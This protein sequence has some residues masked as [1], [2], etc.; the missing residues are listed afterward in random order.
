MSGSAADVGVD[1][2]AAVRGHRLLVRVGDA[3]PV[4]PRVVGGEGWPETPLVIRT[5]GVATATVLT[6]AKR[7][8]GE[9][10]TTLHLLGL[11]PDGAD[12]SLADVTWL[13]LADLDR[14]AHPPAVATAIRTGLAEYA[15]DVP[16]PAERPAW[17]RP[18]WSAQ[19][20]GWVD[21]QLVRVGLT[22]TGES[23]AVKVW[24]LSAVLRVPV[25]DA[26]RAT[27]VYVKATCDHFRAEP[28]VTRLVA[29][30]A[31]AVVPDVLAVDRAR[32]WILMRPFTDGDVERR[33]ETAP[34]AARAIAEVQLRLVG[35]DED[36]LAAGAPDRRLAP[37]LAAFEQ[38]VT[39]GLELPLLS[40]DERQQAVGMLPWVRSELAALAAVGMPASIG[41][42]D[43]HIG[44][45]VADAAGIRIFDWSDAALTCPVLD[46]LLLA[47]SAGGDHERSTLD[48][49][50]G[51]WAEHRPEVDVAAAL[52]LAA[53][54]H[55]V[56]QA[57]SYEGIYGGQEEQSRWEMAG[58]SARLLRR[59]IARWVKAGRP[60]LPV[61]AGRL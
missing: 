3:G 46:A 51:V 61:A 7:L 31:P 14:L 10:T 33:P 15:G 11:P 18:G 42:G 27:C 41:H 32:A 36:V 1:L 16:W 50:A 13:G 37:T 55:L 38:L 49:Y 12:P 52:R 9:P 29:S 56:Y 17:Y 48:A 44:N 54:P 45:Y 35:R 57:V 6:P 5:A 30:Y 28:A 19:V 22:R 8:G 2:V 40:A 25:L 39:A 34:A 21:G 24:S 4:L 59:L 43:L 47:A 60:C 20:D 58:V 53:V 26:G 23:E